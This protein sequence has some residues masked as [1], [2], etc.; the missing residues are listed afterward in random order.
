M[1]AKGCPLDISKDKE[2]LFRLF[3]FGHVAQVGGML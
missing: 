2:G 1:L 3:H